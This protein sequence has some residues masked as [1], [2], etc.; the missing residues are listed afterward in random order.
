MTEE[1]SGEPI[2][3]SSKGRAIP[4]DISA[5]R[6]TDDVV[7]ELS[8][9]RFAPSDAEPGAPFAAAAGDPAVRLLQSL[10][11]DVD[12]G[13]PPLA[14]ERRAMAS[15]RPRRFGPRT[16][17]ALGLTT[18]MLATT[19]VAAAGGLGAPFQRPP[20]VTHHAPGPHPRPG[21]E[22]RD[23]SGFA[24][25][26]QPAQ[27]TPRTRKAGAPHHPPHRPPQWPRGQGPAGYDVR[28][29]QRLQAGFRDSAQRRGG[30]SEGSHQQ[31]GPERFNGGE[32]K[33]KSCD[34]QGQGSGQETGRGGHC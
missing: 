1:R 26:V 8:L 12:Q 6:D 32:Y 7:E 14:T 10:I 3:F 21:T 23:A 5:I 28:D 19:G 27:G 33:D 2:D 20:S 9:R 18:A 29:L 22:V 30:R 13:A 16:V 15:R 17:V 11:S 25:A 4:L 24:E 31:P 34:A